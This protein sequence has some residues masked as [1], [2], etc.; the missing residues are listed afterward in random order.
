M[1]RRAIRKVFGFRSPPLSHQDGRERRTLSRFDRRV[2]CRGTRHRGGRTRSKGSDDGGK[3][4]ISPYDAKPA[5]RSKH[6]PSTRR[7]GLGFEG[8]HVYLFDRFALS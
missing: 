6:L 1:E 7:R 4:V 2:I 3:E 8:D 5:A